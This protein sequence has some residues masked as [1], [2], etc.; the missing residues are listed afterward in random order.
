[1]QTTQISSKRKW[2]G[3]KG[4]LVEGSSG[5]IEVSKAGGLLLM[6][7][8]PTTED[9]GSY[10][11][12]AVY[13]IDPLNTGVQLV[14]YQDITCEDCPTKQALVIQTDGKIGCRVSAN[15]PAAITWQKDSEILPDRYI[16]ENDE[17]KVTGA[18]S[19]VKENI[20]CEQWS[21]RLESSKNW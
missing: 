18:T 16:I 13:N 4:D 11:C 5:P 19:E 20:L 14:F 17:I 10:N 8:E 7:S 21:S 2:V 15:P 12:S 1:M 6:F 3:P 9:S